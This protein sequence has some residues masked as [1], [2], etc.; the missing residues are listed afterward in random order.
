MASKIRRGTIIAARF[1]NDPLAWAYRN[2][3]EVTQVALNVNSR[4]Q[5][6]ETNYVKK[7]GSDPLTSNFNAGGNIG[8]ICVSTGV[9]GTWKGYGAINP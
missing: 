7:D 1:S 2:V 3:N 6:V 4:L 5:T 8:Y 9:P